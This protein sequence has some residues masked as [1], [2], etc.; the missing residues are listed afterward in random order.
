VA[1]LSE[2]NPNGWQLSEWT[3]MLP[4]AGLGRVGEGRAAKC[5]A[6]GVALSPL[7]CTQYGQTRPAS[8]TAGSTLQAESEISR[9][10]AERPMANQPDAGRRRGG[11]G[12][13]RALRI[14][15]GSVG[16]PVGRLLPNVEVQ[17]GIGPGLDGAPY[18]CRYKCS[19]GRGE[20]A[21]EGL[22]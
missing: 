10:A 3:T 1:C 17:M 18:V 9:A 16:V 20:G 2:P 14:R 21:R 4:Q 11:A 5:C 8:E 7:C 12:S 15:R 13:L 19:V 22:E 6:V